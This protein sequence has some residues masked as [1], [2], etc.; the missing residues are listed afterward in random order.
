[1]HSPQINSC[2]TCTDTRTALTQLGRQSGGQ[3]GVRSCLSPRTV[4]YY[5]RRWRSVVRFTLFCVAWGCNSEGIWNIDTFP[6]SPGFDFLFVLGAVLGIHS[7][8]L[9]S[10][11]NQSSGYIYIYIYMYMQC[12]MTISANATMW[13]CPCASGKVIVAVVIVV[14]I[15]LYGWN[16]RY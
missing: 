5:S 10:V 3:S 13:C 1:M 14:V 2:S 15:I 9:Q 8:S 6:T 11:T 4:R 16:H 7:H 12:V